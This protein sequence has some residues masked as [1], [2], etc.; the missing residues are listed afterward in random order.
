MK[1]EMYDNLLDLE[2]R[3]WWWRARRRI[4]REILESLP[5]PGPKRLLDI[6]C[7]AG[8]WLKEIGYG[9]GIEKSPIA[10]AICK[11]RGLDVKPNGFNSHSFEFDVV[12]AFDVMEHCAFPG[13]IVSDAYSRLKPGG[14]SI[15]T[16]PA[17]NWLWTRW[18]DLNEHKRRYTRHELIADLEYQGFNVEF[19]SYFNFYLFPL[20]VWR[21][22]SGNATAIIPG[23][24]I[25]R[26]L[27]RI[28]QHERHWLAARRAFPWGSSIIAIVRKAL[29]GMDDHY[30]VCCRICNKCF[31]EK[32]PLINGEP[33]EWYCRK[34]R[35]KK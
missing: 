12:T 17:Y 9:V 3:H 24:F 22:I 33:P 21:K 23:R 15:V 7:G 30:L 13:D 27:E 28:F 25:N 11:S 34:H 6:G 20:A 2:Q 16:V 19:A 1:P 35:I 29:A 32:R 10:R 26:L 5:P 4:F 18:D 14:Y 8:Q 31:S